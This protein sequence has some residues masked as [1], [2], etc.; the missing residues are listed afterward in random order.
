M[1]NLYKIKTISISVEKLIS[2][3]PAEVYTAWLDKNCPGSPWHGVE[4]AIIDPNVDGLFYRMHRSDDEEYELAHYGRFILLDSHKKIQHTW[5]SQH[6]R[7]LESIVTVTFEK[8]TDRTLVTIS[9][10]NLPDDEKGRMH[11]HGWKYYLQMIQE[12]FSQE[13]ENEAG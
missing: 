4:Q 13:D 3:T 2:A 10:E 1:K 7:G 6:T 5:V 8:L 12:T 9:H 11:M